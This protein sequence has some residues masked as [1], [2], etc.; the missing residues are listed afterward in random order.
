MPTT[1]PCQQPMTQRRRRHHPGEPA[2][3][4]TIEAQAAHVYEDGDNLELGDHPIILSAPEMPQEVQEERGRLSGSA[5]QRG[6]REGGHAALDRMRGA[7]THGFRLPEEHSHA[8]IMIRGG[9][10]VTGRDGNPD[11]VPL[12]RPLA[13]AKPESRPPGSGTAEPRAEDTRHH[14]P[15]FDRV[16][17]SAALERFV[18]PD[19]GVGPQEKPS[20]AAASA[21]RAQENLAR[22][23]APHGSAI[24]PPD[25]TA[26][27][28]ASKAATVASISPVG[29]G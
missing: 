28:I 15:S 10:E 13:P 8:E 22:L 7:Q 29:I 4:A 18:W 26:F 9:S 25:A 23:R 27:V 16:G 17:T 19:R 21:V 24:R 11:A 20:A 14:G 6:S 12:R 3:A 5:L 1:L 2:A